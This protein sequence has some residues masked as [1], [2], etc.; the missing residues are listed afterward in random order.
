MKI[1]KESK[2][3]QVK[4]GVRLNIKKAP[5]VEVPKNVYTRKGKHKSKTSPEE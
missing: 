5:K 2:S 1:K 4:K 3:E